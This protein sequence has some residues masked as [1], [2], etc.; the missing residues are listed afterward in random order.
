MGKTVT[1]SPEYEFDYVT[2]GTDPIIGDWIVQGIED[3]KDLYKYWTR[4]NVVQEQ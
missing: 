2:S 1:V 4:H 3:G